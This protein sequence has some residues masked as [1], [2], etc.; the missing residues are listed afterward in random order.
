MGSFF[1][2]NKKD[3]TVLILRRYRSNIIDERRMGMAKKAKKKKP[4]D[5]RVEIAKYTAIGA[6]ALPTLELIKLIKQII[7]QFFN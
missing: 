3:D 4:N 7:K 5:Y 1:I 2:S 6:W